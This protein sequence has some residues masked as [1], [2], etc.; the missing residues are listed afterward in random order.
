[1][2]VPYYP[3][4]FPAPGIVPPGTD[5]YIMGT[6]QD[7]SDIYYGVIWGARTSIVIALEVVG[8]SLLVGVVLGAVAGFYGG[9]ID[10]A[11]MRITDVFLAVPVSYWPWPSCQYWDQASIT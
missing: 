2:I 10:D 7:A 3:G 1:M 5:G 9:M 8:V 4:K 11:L 6:G